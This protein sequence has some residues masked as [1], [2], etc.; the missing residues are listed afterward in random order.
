M[1]GYFDPNKENG[2]TFQL[3]RDTN[4]HSHQP[5]YQIYL[6]NDWYS[7]CE[8]K[9]LNISTQFYAFCQFSLKYQLSSTILLGSIV[10]A[11]LWLFDFGIPM[12]S[13]CHHY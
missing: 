10:A 13:V 1:D 11:I 12:H 7:L 3:K 2:R 6:L 4:D 8:Y 9:F 5:A